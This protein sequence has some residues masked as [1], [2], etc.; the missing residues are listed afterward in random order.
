MKY[1]PE[2]KATIG[3]RAAEHGVVATCASQTALYWY[4][5]HFET[6]GQSC[7]RVHEGR[8]LDLIRPHFF[9]TNH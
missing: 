4:H 1:T 8:I 3:K 5:G 9:T 7:M 6:R 2:Q